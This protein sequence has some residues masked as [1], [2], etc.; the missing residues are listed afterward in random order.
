MYLEETK[1]PVFGTH[2]MLIVAP[3]QYLSNDGVVVDRDPL[4]EI[5]LN[6]KPNRVI[7]GSKT[8]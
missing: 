4:G 3:K 2:D 8:P 1:V 6:N 7:L 5:E